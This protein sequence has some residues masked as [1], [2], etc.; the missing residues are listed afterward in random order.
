MPLGNFAINR[1][2]SKMDLQAYKYCFYTFRQQHHTYFSLS[3]TVR[4]F[5]KAETT[6][7]L[8][9]SGQHALGF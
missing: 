1:F 2:I 6:M 9:L 4:D 5:H 3:S 8:R 7:S